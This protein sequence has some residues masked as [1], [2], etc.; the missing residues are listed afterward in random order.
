MEDQGFLSEDLSASA[1]Q[2]WDSAAESLDGALPRRTPAE[3]Q[4]AL[5]TSKI[6][7]S[8]TEP[9]LQGDGMNAYM[10][11]KVSTKTHLPQFA[12]QDFS[13]VRRYSDFSWL[14]HQLQYPN[15]MIPP[16]PEKAIT[17]NLD[18]DFV[19][20]RVHGLNRF[21]N[22]V[23]T[24]PVL[25]Y[26]NDLQTFLEADEGT[27]KQ[28]KDVAF[29]LRK[30]QVVC[31]IEEGG[32]SRWFK[33]AFTS[34]SNTISGAPQEFWDPEHEEQAR[35]IAELKEKVRT[36]RKQVRSVVNA[37]K[38]LGQSHMELGVGL[39]RHS[40]YETGHCKNSFRILAKGCGIVGKLG[41]EQ[42]LADALQLE[43][44]LAE[45]VGDCEA[46]E[47]LNANRNS[48]MVVLQT[49]RSVHQEKIDA[50]SKI[51]RS[52]GDRASA[53]KAAGLICAINEAA[54]KE[55]DAKNVYDDLVR[56]TKD[57]IEEWN[58]ERMEVYHRTMLQY[59]K[60]TRDYYALMASRWEQTCL[61][62]R[63]EFDST[64][65]IEVPDW[66]QKGA[67]GERDYDC[68]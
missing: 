46:V 12:R 64:I 50:Q 22:R 3:P 62:L 51:V 42:S 61:E 13:V 55:A 59:T 26:S 63:Q 16:L 43:S 11:Y 54:A 24:H 10:T 9:L 34:A 37:R 29:E 25:Q 28:V 67:N 4:Q 48:Q 31:S 23:V 30:Q 1:W 45:T 21:L 44:V 18:P 17:G 20:V 58:T 15:V 66:G 33:E 47:Q 52:S 65:P 27:L 68:I 56:G 5:P 49:A 8:V 7:V 6:Q 38:L 53:S 36:V 60:L 14:H 40:D 57:E 2:W 35:Q 32:I 19:T 41:S 39:M